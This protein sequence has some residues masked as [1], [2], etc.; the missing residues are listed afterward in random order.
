ME[1]L[2]PFLARW[3]TLKEASQEHVLVS[4]LRQWP[5]Y[6]DLQ[7]QCLDCVELKN[8]REITELGSSILS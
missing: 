6:T 2:N 5:T 7:G 4:V 1:F 3:K 8:R